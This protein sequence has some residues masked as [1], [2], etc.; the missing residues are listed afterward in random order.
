MHNYGPLLLGDVDHM[1]KEITGVFFI[2]I[3]IIAYTG[4]LF[5][6]PMI[7][8][9]RAKRRRRRQVGDLI[10]AAHEKTPLVRKQIEILSKDHRLTTR[11]TQILLRNQ[12]SEAIKSGNEPLIKYFQELYE[13]LERDEPFE[14]LPSDVRLHLERIKESIGGDK[15]YLMEPLAA[16]LQDLSAANRRKERWMWGLT[17]S[18]FVAGVVGVFFGAIP[19]IPSFAAKAAVLSSTN[20]PGQETPPS[21]ERASAD[22]QTRTHIEH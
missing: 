7:I 1:L 14:G 2:V 19:Y 22:K 11:D 18:S 20:L 5:L 9:E 6:V 10:S 3:V 8:D 13:Q 21:I 4:T 17:I 12:F 15:D 16:Q